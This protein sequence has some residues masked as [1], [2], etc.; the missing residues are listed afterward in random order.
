MKPFVVPEVTFKGHSRSSAVSCVVRFLGLS[1]RN[2]QG[3]LH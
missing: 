3:R 2:H 1:I